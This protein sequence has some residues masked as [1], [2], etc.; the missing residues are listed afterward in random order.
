MTCVKVN[1]LLQFTYF[2]VTLCRWDCRKKSGRYCRHQN[3]HEQN[4]KYS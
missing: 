2:T 1:T 3:I 4:K